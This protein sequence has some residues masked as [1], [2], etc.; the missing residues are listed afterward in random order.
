MALNGN[1]LFESDTVWLVAQERI[2]ILAAP[3]VATREVSGLI[4]MILW[5][6]ELFVASLGIVDQR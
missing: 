6:P 4:G 2:E 1:R 3:G 5:C